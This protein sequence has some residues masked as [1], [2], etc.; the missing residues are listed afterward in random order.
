MDKLAAGHEVIPV[1]DCDNFDF[2]EGCQG[3]EA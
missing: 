1:G 3:H 2:K